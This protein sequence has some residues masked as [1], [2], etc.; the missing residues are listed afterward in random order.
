M[1]CC[2]PSLHPLPHISR[3]LR[4]P[5]ARNGCLRPLRGARHLQTIK[6]TADHSQAFVPTPNRP[7]RFFPASNTLASTLI[8]ICSIRF[9]LPT[10]LRYSTPSESPTLSSPY[11]GRRWRLL[12]LSTIVTSR[13]CSPTSKTSPPTKNT[14]RPSITRS[15]CSHFRFPDASGTYFHAVRC[16]S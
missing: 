9:L 11:I 10:I 8:Y 7:A 14:H 3:T 5:A 1:T 2:P 12:P 16:K 4:A 6:R 13:I 15:Q